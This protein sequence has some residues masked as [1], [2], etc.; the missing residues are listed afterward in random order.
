[1]KKCMI[2]ASVLMAASMASATSYT[3]P[4]TAGGDITDPGNWNLAALPTSADSIVFNTVQANPYCMGLLSSWTLSSVGFKESCEIDLGA[5]KILTS[6]GSVVFDGGSKTFTLKSGKVEAAGNRIF[7]GDGTSG[8]TLIVEGANTILKSPEATVGGNNFF[9]LSPNYGNNH[10]IIRDGATYDGNVMM[11]VNSTGAK[12]NSFT[13]TGPGTKWTTRGARNTRLYVADNQSIV[14]SNRATAVL[15]GVP[16]AQGA[17]NEGSIWLGTVNNSAV[18]Q[19]HRLVVADGASLWT[20]QSITAGRNGSNCEIR[21]ADGGYI[22]SGYTI[23]LGFNKV[24]AQTS[25]NRLTV[26]GTGNGLYAAGGLTIGYGAG[27]HANGFVVEPGAE[28]AYGGSLIAGENQADDSNYMT[29]AG[30]MSVT[31]KAITTWYFGA[32]A[33]SNRFEVVTGGEFEANNTWFVLGHNSSSTNNEL[34]VR[35]G[36]TFACNGYTNL[37]GQSS[38]NN[39]MV[40]DGG[41]VA[42]NHNDLIVGFNSSAPNNLLEVKNGGV[43]ALSFGAMTIGGSGPRSRL[44]VSGG[45]RLAFTNAS[46]RV[47]VGS[48]AKGSV[49]ELIDSELTF[50][51]TSPDGSNGIGV[52]SEGGSASN[53]LRF[54]RSR[55]EKS[56]ANSML[57]VGSG[58]SASNRSVGNRLELLDGSVMK[59]KRCIFGDYSKDCQLV[60]SNSTLDIS[61]DFQPNFKD[62]SDSNAQIHFYGDNPHLSAVNLNFYGDATYNFHIPR[63]GYALT[64]VRNAV[65]YG[66]AIT[67]RTNACKAKPL[68]RITGAEG[69]RTRGHWTL[70]RVNNN[71][72]NFLR[73]G[74]E[75]TQDDIEC[76]PGIRA[77]VTERTIEVYVNSQKGMTLVV[78]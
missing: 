70:M 31:N 68:I 42:F 23:M 18:G 15:S 39:R 65:V 30:T 6:S 21:L 16:I 51:N 27:S 28:L 47:G 74:T 17:N 52:G 41:Q 13:V 1:M 56:Q 40:V 20:D 55:F 10:V 2:T 69:P 5:N 44:S 14:I 71:S 63:E 54:V 77:V 38:A 48:W 66:D 26:S 64:N 19:N 7:L 33:P 67:R 37:I 9:S 43:F 60:I 72:W 8:N 50:A 36:A 53:V 24:S 4:G 32:N 29:V 3:W 22:G 57:T 58:A 76:G 78:R 61:G 45:S 11:A 62:L 46:L 25:G 59:V 34:I 49:A 35:S 73:P 12:N 75:V